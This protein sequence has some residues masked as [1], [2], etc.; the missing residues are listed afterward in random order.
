M[1]P[2]WSRGTLWNRINNVRVLLII[3]STY[4]FNNTETRE[5]GKSLMQIKKSSYKVLT[6]CD[7]NMRIY[8][9][10]YGFFLKVG[11]CICTVYWINERT[12]YQSILN[13]NSGKLGAPPLHCCDKSLIL[14]M[15]YPYKLLILLMIY[16]YAVFVLP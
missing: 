15:I 16:P 13:A 11:F 6:N 2:T 14:L 3:V 9:Y 10:T 1:T 12:H 5:H 7:I 8:A 4:F